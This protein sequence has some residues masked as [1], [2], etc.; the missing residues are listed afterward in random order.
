MKATN[1]LTLMEHYHH[2]PT[3]TFDPPPPYLHSIS[4]LNVT[5][6]LAFDLPIGRWRAVCQCVQTDA[7]LT[8]L[9]HCVDA[10]MCV[11]QCGMCVCVCEHHSPISQFSPA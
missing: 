4:F 8:I 10:C 9:C 6:N 11:R 5:D 3:L 1:S 2:S 7:G